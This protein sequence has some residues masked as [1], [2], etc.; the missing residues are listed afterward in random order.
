MAHLHSAIALVREKCVTPQA[1]RRFLVQESLARIEDRAMN[2]DFES[3]VDSISTAYDKGEYILCMKLC[4]EV[5][6]D[7][8]ALP[9]ATKASLLQFIFNS[10]RK[11]LDLQT[12]QQ[13]EDNPV[14]SFCGRQPPS[15][16]LGAGPSAFICN[17]CVELFS[18]ALKQPSAAT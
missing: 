12:P 4:S 17:E 11:L 14:C 7:Q 9:E 8:K 3:A 15:V 5:L 1:C 13:G 2:Y 6:V 18:E 16:R 10:S